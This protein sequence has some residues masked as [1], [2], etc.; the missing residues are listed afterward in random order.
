V[1]FNGIGDN[2]K[3]NKKR[4]DDCRVDYRFIYNLFGKTFPLEQ[5]VEIASFNDSNQQSRDQGE[6]G[7]NKNIPAETVRVPR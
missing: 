2:R 6:N 3:D 5:L 4:Q 1:Q 7:G